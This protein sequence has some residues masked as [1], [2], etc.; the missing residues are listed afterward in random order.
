MEWIELSFLWQSSG[1]E[2]AEAGLLLPEVGLKLA[3]P[4]AE[5]QQEPQFITALIFWEGQVRH[6]LSLLRAILEV[7]SAYR[8]ICEP[9]LK[10]YAMQI[11]LNIGILICHHV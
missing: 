5:R 3:F 6:G 7:E 10:R 4:D 8:G 11:F 9:R 1:D 2:R